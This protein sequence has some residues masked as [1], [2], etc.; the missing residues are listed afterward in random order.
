V[1]PAFPTPAMLTVAYVTGEV[2]VTGDMAAL[3]DALA[4]LPRDHAVWF[5]TRGLGSDPHIE[6][7]VTSGAAWAPGG[8]MWQAA[9][10]FR[11][12]MDAAAKDYERRRKAT[13]DPRR[14]TIT[15][16][17]FAALRNRRSAADMLLALHSHNAGM[18]SP[19][20]AA[21]INKIALWCADRA[22]ESAHA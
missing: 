5:L 10:G 7:Q 3:G 15:G 21:E 2:S 12:R 6:A 11:T 17:A 18:S 1:Q 14:S 4:E 20:P 22:R 8:R 16:M 13:A 19:L 9:A